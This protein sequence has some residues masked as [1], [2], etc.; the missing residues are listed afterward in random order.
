M[1]KVQKTEKSNRPEL[2]F[3]NSNIA[4]QC[5]KANE[6]FKAI[7]EKKYSHLPVLSAS[8]EKGMVY[9]DNNGINIKYDEK[10]LQNYKRVLPG[11]FVIHLRSFQGGFAHSNIEGICSPAYTVIDFQDMHNQDTNFWAS[12]FSS[13][14]FIKRLETVTYGIRDGR[15]ISFKDFS[16]L[17]FFVPSFQEQVRI[18]NFL[19]EIDVTVSLHQHELT[20][21]KQRRKAFLQKMFPKKGESVPGLLLSNHSKYWE[22]K[23]I[24][25][26][27]DERNERSSEGELL[28]VTIKSGVVKATSLD[29]KDNSSNNKSNYKVVKKGDIAYN[30]M[31]MWQGASGLSLH[32]GIV[33]PAYT[34]LIPKEEIDSNFFSY[35][36]KLNYMIQTFQSNSQG[37]TSDTWNL[38]YPII[39]TIKI[40]V[41]PY[42]E[43]Q[44]I[45]QFFK[46]LDEDIALHEQKLEKLK[47]M[48]KA[49]LQKMFV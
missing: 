39:K 38:K 24:G 15:S 13:Y 35:Y 6:L 37:L 17:K 22:V 49:F 32:N 20:L 2:S 4:W 3:S 46:Q 25:N 48:K 18:G 33:S 44:K 19:K 43:Q 40:A 36:F 26:C 45:G 30:S 11:Q 28:S 16:S 23:T 42:N 41:P 14:D 47:E 29:R 12:I 7:S 31:R 8:Q 10:N 1:N 5:Y 27:F 21:L 34:I 9:R